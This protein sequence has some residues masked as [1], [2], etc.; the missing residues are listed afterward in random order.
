MKQIIFILF[1]TLSF[2]GCAQND[3]DQIDTASNKVTENTSDKLMVGYSPLGDIPSQSLA[4]MNKE[5]TEVWRMVGQKMYVNYSF[6]D[7]AFYINNKKKILN[8]F[9][10]FYEKVLMKSDDVTYLSFARCYH[11]DS[12][13]A[14]F[15]LKRMTTRAENENSVIYVGSALVWSQGGARLRAYVRAVVDKHGKIIRTPSVQCVCYPASAKFDG[16]AEG[17]AAGD[18]TFVKVTVNGSCEVYGNSYEISNSVTVYLNN[19]G[20]DNE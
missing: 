8:D 15:L 7:S 10:N 2:W 9:K 1:I 17:E 5:E 16:T 20:K 4:K 14:V 19:E 13:K 6:L 12:D 11:N 3:N 18:G